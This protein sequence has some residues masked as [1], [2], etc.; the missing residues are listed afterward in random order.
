MSNKKSTYKL[1]FLDRD[2]VIN[3]NET[4]Y[5]KRV[6]EWIP[7]PNSL[8]AIAKAYKN[9]YKFAVATNQ[10]GIARKY[11][12]LADL[13]KMHKKMN[14]LLENLGGKFEYIAYCPHLPELRYPV[15]SLSL[16]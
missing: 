1:I 8:E 7:I 3:Q 11:Y 6:E 16:D 13:S 14:M 10:S 9:G 15:E 5:I 12:S 4:G 2:G